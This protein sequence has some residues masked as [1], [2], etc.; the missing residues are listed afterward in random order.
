MILIKEELL[1]EPTINTDSENM[2]F[3]SIDRKAFFYNKQPQ[4]VSRTD[5][6]QF[7]GAYAAE[8]RV[9]SDLRVSLEEVY[10]VSVVF[11]YVSVKDIFKSNFGLS[12]MA[13]EFIRTMPYKFTNRTLIVS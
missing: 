2:L 8:K 10:G 6:R 13:E 4:P 7:K 1:L 12:Q 9:L 11:D 3:D 5:I